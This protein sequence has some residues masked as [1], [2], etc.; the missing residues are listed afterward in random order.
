MLGVPL[1]VDRYPVS[2][3]SGPP[4][5]LRAVVD[6][7]AIIGWLWSQ[8][9]AQW[10]SGSAHPRLAVGAG[11]GSYTATDAELTRPLLKPPE[12]G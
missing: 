7:D 10:R 2:A 6:Q 5:P 9:L 3:R 4:R 1:G 8:N 11:G 12:P